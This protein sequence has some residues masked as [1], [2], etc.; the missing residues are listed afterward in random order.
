MDLYSRQIIG[1]AMADHL[2]TELVENALDMALT[3]RR[4]PRNVLHHSDRGS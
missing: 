2:R 3:Q 1:M 4:P